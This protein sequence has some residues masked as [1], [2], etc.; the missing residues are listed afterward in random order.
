MAALALTNEATRLFL[1]SDLM[2]IVDRHGEQ[3]AVDG[4]VYQRHETGTVRYFTLC[5]P[6]DIARWTYRAIGVRKWPDDCAAGA[7]AGRE[8]CQVSGRR[9]RR[10]S[11]LSSQFASGGERDGIPNEKRASS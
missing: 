2:A 10:Y 1:Q 6:L 8:Y 5:G 7:A 3:V 9:A 4:V 11:G